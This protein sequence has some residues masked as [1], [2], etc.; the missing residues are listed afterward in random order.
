MSSPKLSI[1]ITNHNNGKYLDLCLDSILKSTDMT[2][3]EI[4]VFNDNCDDNSEEIVKK[5]VKSC[6]SI[7]FLGT[8]VTYGL[9]MALNIACSFA[10]P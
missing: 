1:I 6:K 8:K 3:K 7:A 5:Y 9:A 4:I 2:D 10:H